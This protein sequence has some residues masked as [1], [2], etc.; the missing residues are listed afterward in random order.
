MKINVRESIRLPA[1]ENSRFR[2]VRHHDGQKVEK[3]RKENRMQGGMPISVANL[4]N[5]FPIKKISG[6][7]EVRSHLKSMGFNEGTE[8]KLITQLDGD[9]IIHVK[10][11]RV[12]INKD[13][14]RHI[15]V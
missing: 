1:D 14:A 9:V 7:T 5:A 11:S 6:N 8:V 12:A 2:Q 13:Q 3:Q 4:G 10:E 15:L